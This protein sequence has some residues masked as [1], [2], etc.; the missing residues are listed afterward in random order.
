L[1]PGAS[2]GATT[3][4]Q[5]LSGC[6]TYRFPLAS[7][8][9]WTT[10]GE[11][12]TPADTE[13][14]SFTYGRKADSYISKA[15][16]LDGDVWRLIG[17]SVRVGDEAS[18]ES[19]T[20]VGIS[21]GLDRWAKEVRSEFVYTKYRA[22]LVCGGLVVSEHFEIKATDW[23]G[24]IRTGADL[25]YLDDRCYQ[26]HFPYLAEFGANGRFDRNSN[27]YGTFV[28]AAT[29][30]LGGATVSLNA[31]SGMSRYVRISLKFGLRA[32]HVLCGSNALLPTA[33]RIFAGA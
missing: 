26:D 9:A 17:G 22:E 16:S 27:R 19:S 13:V 33:S 3:G 20:E 15:I 14:A 4:S 28:G 23:V 2:G 12:H 32:R 5:A 30:T 6:A 18:S 29:V 1:I 21:H 25:R 7:T 10:I 31:R 11:L 8:R 24:N